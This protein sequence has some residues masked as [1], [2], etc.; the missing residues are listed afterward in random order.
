M[1]LL[2][3]VYFIKK[4]KPSFFLIFSISLLFLIKEISVG[5]NGRPVENLIMRIRRE[6]NDAGDQ[7][8]NNNDERNRFA[9]QEPTSKNE[10]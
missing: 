1:K 5:H 6:K 2:W 7:K 4:E 3:F 10:V 8:N 9:L